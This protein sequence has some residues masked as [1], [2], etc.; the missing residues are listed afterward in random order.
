MHIAFFIIR[1]VL[2][3]AIAAHGSQKLFGW[4]GGPGLAG[5]SGFMEMLG[6]RPGRLFAVAASA[7]EIV[8]GI[9]TVLGLGGALGPALVVMLMLV[10]IFTVHISNGFFQQANGWEL[11]AFYIT[12]ALAVAFAGNGPISL[13]NALGLSVLTNPVH[14][15]I[16]MTAAVVLALLNLAARRP[17][18][19]NAPAA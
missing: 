16:A 8:A 7:G 11:N 19:Q 1:L 15:W 5:A 12:T 9:L 17:A 13:D 2:G 18:P 6:F 14:V 4:F 10:A 3:L